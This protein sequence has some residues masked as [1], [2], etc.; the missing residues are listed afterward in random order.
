M[1]S[2]R[3][4]EVASVKQQVEDGTLWWSRER[5]NALVEP[6]PD[7]DIGCVIEGQ[8]VEGSDSSGDDPWSDHDGDSHDD[9]GDGASAPALSKA[10]ASEG[11]VALASDDPDDVAEA[12]RYADRLANLERM[13]QAAKDNMIP[14][15]QFHIEHEIEKLRKQHHLGTEGKAPSAVLSRFV[16]A[17]REAEETALAEERRKA[18]K[19][20]EEQ[21]V[22][23]AAAKKL[24][25]EKDAAK[26][27]HEK[28][29]EA[30]AKVPKTFT[31]VELGQGHKTG[32]AKK[33]L[34]ARIAALNRL[35]LRAPPLPAELELDWDRWA[36]RYASYEGRK[37]KAAVGAFFLLELKDIMEE[38]GEHLLRE[39]GDKKVEGGNPNALAEFIKKMNK[40]CRKIHLL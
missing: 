8:E 6:F 28:K 36:L 1:S 29:K 11:V 37:S 40:K 25:M 34:D 2:V 32:G 7:G 14:A 10:L 30:L 35:K 16:Q 5:L 17:R 24:K 15:L 4:A 22:E 21:R 26:A 27:E 9:D 19:R 13:R 12:R 20:R 3:D 33:H 39:K 38:L 18:L 31:A 23:R